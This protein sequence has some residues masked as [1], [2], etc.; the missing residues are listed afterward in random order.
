MS[1]LAEVRKLFVKRSG[2][3]ELV[4]DWETDDWSDNGANDYLRAGQRWLDRLCPSPVLLKKELFTLAAGNHSIDVPDMRHV[5]SIDVTDGE[6]RT[7]LIPIPL[8][9]MRKL[10][11]EEWADVERGT[12][13]YWTRLAGHESTETPVDKLVSSTFA[14][15]FTLQASIAS[16]AA[17]MAA[18][19]YQVAQWAL[20]SAQQTGVT[21]D[22]G[23]TI[24]AFGAGVTTSV[25]QWL[26]GKTIHAPAKLVVSGSITSGT[27]SVLI[28]KLND[29]KTAVTTLQTIPLVSPMVETEFPIEVDGADFITISSTTAIAN[30]SSIKVFYYPPMKRDTLLFL[31]PADKAYTLSVFGAAYTAS[32]DDDN[33]VSWW[34][35]KHPEILIRAARLQLEMDAHRNSTGVKDF[36]AMLEADVRHIYY[37]TV[38]E[39][40]AASPRRFRMGVPR[41]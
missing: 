31:P 8:Y 30:I 12:P 22:N 13:Q 1:T 34:S 40:C 18:N 38:A 32:L 10:Y 2:H 35:E 14:A 24:G 19:Y 15:A 4:T 41:R 21:N 27:V 20:N 17:Y 25:Y 37:E 28:G 11:T 3:Y 26:Y 29:A 5:E 39:Q 16:Y 9:E 33:D 7:P 6:E 23:L 36:A